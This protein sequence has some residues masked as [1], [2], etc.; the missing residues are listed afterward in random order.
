MTPEKS[1]SDPLLQLRRTTAEQHRAIERQ[2]LIRLLLAPGLTLC[3]YAL[4]L[5]ALAVWYEALE[6]R[7]CVSLKCHR[8]AGNVPARLPA[9]SMEP[10]GTGPGGGEYRYLSRAALL[11]RDLACLHGMIRESR[12]RR[13]PTS[14]LACL[15][16]MIRKSRADA[17]ELPPSPDSGLSLPDTHCACRLIGVLYVVEGAT[18]GGR[19]LA[20]RVEEHLGLRPGQ[21]T[22]Y[23]RL[24]QEGEWPRFRAF[25]RLALGGGPDQR[26]E[27]VSRSTP[28][29][30]CARGC[31]TSGA[32]VST[33]ASAAQATFES[34]HRHLDAWAML[35]QG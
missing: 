22:R 12:A 25:A 31:G 29:G 9:G 13:A 30:A 16:G 23:L 11:R 27:H 17:R 18:L 7:L 21:G 26:H 20:P 15:H 10:P 2:Q 5:A 3:D 6:S 35:A 32:P 33:A 19:I 14:D 34:L 28:G 8:E 4:T 24:H 1:E